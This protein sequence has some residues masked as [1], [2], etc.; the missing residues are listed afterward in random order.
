ML[1]L[2]RRTN[3]ALFSSSSLLLQRSRGAFSLLLRLN[4]GV[5]P[6]EVVEGKEKSDRRRRMKASIT[7]ALSSVDQSDHCS[8]KRE[9]TPNLKARLK[10]HSV[11][12]LEL[13]GVTTV[14]VLV[15][16]FGDGEI[17]D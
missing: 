11:K 3:W 10:I 4:L 17:E 13:S 1:L 6:G 8:C 16:G 15:S 14:N 5:V 7:D 12:S 9:R 2:R